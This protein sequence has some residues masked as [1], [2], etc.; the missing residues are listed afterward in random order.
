MT[1]SAL[2]HV[3]NRRLL[4]YCVSAVAIVLAR[5]IHVPTH[6]LA[7]SDMDLVSSQIQLLN[8]LAESQSTKELE[9]MR[10]LCNE[11]ARRAHIAL[12]G[13]LPRTE[14][15]ELAANWSQIYETNQSLPSYGSRVDTNT[16]RNV[17][18]QT[19]SVVLV[20]QS[21]STTTLSAQSYSN[22]M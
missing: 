15:E 4:S 2:M 17:D 16:D 12:Y 1:H 11:L 10:Q 6:N 14:P 3:F 20:G 22:S 5:I 8:S 7:Y 9:L 18:P 13:D 21:C 19:S